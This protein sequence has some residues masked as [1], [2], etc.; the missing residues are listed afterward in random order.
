MGASPTASATPSR[1]AARTAAAHAAPNTS[2]LSRIDGG[3][4][5]GAPCSD[6]AASSRDGAVMCRLPSLRGCLT[7]VRSA[8]PRGLRGTAAVGLEGVAGLGV[9]LVDDVGRGVARQGVVGD[10]V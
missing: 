2:S 9:F 3:G 7:A 1:A 8:K 10:P 6:G 5:D 4:A